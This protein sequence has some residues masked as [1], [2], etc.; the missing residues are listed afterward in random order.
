MSNDKHLLETLHGDY[1]MMVMQICMGYTKGDRDLAKD[2]SQ[3]VFINIWRALK[4]FKNESGYKT[5][6]YRITVNTCLKYIR[7]KK[8]THHRTIEEE[9]LIA[10]TVS[11][12]PNDQNYQLLYMAIGQLKE[13][14][15]LIMMLM[16]DELKYQEISEIIGI[17]EGNLRVK[18]HRIKKEVKN[19][20]DNG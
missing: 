4:S 8:D 11:D 1:H 3:E 6:I 15:R 12:P 20:F 7:D 5:W 17:S 13:V 18:I 19:I 14:D 10:E 9:S 16:L 2:L